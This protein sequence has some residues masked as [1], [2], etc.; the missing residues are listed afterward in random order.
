M[1][2]LDPRPSV[3]HQVPVRLGGRVSGIVERQVKSFSPRALSGGNDRCDESR[4]APERNRSVRD[5]ERGLAGGNRSARCRESLGTNDGAR[6]A[7]CSGLRSGLRNARRNAN[8]MN[9]ARGARDGHP[10][11]SRSDRFASGTGFRLP[12]GAPRQP[13]SSPTRGQE[14]PPIS[15]LETWLHFL[16]NQ[17]I[18]PGG[19][20]SSERRVALHLL[21][22]AIRRPRV[23]SPPSVLLSV[24]SPDVVSSFQ[25]GH[26]KRRK[27]RAEKDLPAH[28]RLAR[29]PFRGYWVRA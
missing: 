21:Q 2:I 3:G 14:R 4:S 12:L 6:G 8:G 23:P 17:V 28:L 1:R 27:R 11:Q 5:A 18:E 13:K 22:N 24:L 29:T 10:R 26:P 16:F 9:D 19:L 7:L 15:E 20:A 25:S